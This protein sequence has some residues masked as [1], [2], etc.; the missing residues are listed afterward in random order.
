MFYEFPKKSAD[1]RDILEYLEHL[2]YS[3]KPTRL[4]W[5]IFWILESFEIVLEESNCTDIFQIGKHSKNIQ[6]V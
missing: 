5:N 3:E 4:S 2:K 1:S 6:T